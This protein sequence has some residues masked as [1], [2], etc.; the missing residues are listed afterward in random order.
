[1]CKCERPG[2]LS[3]T[4]QTDISGQQATTTFARQEFLAET[5]NPFPCPT[6]VYLDMTFSLEPTNGTALYII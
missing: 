4:L 3:G 2:A 1:M 6:A 5:G